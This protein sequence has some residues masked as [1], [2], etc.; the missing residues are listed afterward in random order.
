MAVRWACC[1]A[2]AIR[3]HG[4]EIVDGQREPQESE[5]MVG[6]SYLREIRAPE[7]DGLREAEP[8]E[9][10]PDTDRRNGRRPDP[11]ELHPE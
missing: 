10:G 6:V 4:G 1:S 3:R 5:Q 9:K 11:L 2:T 7:R 8:I